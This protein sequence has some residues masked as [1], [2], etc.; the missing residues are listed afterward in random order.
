VHLGSRSDHEQLT[1][2]VV[3]VLFKLQRCAILEKLCWLL[4]CVSPIFICTSVIAF[5]VTLSGIRQVAYMLN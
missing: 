5:L 2:A 3:E 1:E 4:P